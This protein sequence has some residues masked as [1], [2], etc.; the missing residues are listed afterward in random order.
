MLNQD[1]DQIDCGYSCERKC[2][3]CKHQIVLRLMK[4]L[5]KL[6]IHINISESILQMIFSI[7]YFVRPSSW[8]CHG[9]RQSSFYN[10][11]LSK[12]LDVLPEYQGVLK[13]NGSF[14]KGC[15][16]RASQVDTQYFGIKEDG[17]CW[18]SKNVVDDYMN[19]YRY[20]RWREGYNCNSGIGGLGTIFVYEL[21]KI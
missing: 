3:M 8:Q 9:C 10:P 14:V 7:G 19:C 18:T 1:E 16:E 15:Y 6:E 4:A 11:V 20:S 13:L 5:L 12:Q 21:G 2:G 17:G